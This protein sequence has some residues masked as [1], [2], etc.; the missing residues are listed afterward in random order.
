[1]SAE[2]RWFNKYVQLDSLPHWLCPACSKGV[3]R[4]AENGFS[5][6]LTALSKRERD[7]EAWQRDWDRWS[8]SLKLACTLC[9]EV[10]ICVGTAS[11]DLDV[12]ERGEMEYVQYLEPRYFHPSLSLVSLPND[13]P[14]ECRLAIEEACRLLWASPAASANAL[15]RAV[16]IFLDTQGVVKIRP[17]PNGKERR[18]VLDA[19]LE[20]FAQ[21]QASPWISKLLMPIRIIGNAGSHRWDEK[22]RQ[23]LVTC[24]TLIEFVLSEFYN[25]R[26]AKLA[27]L[28]AE[29][30]GI[31]QRKGLPKP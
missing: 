9:A 22:M 12:D 11:V 10:V 4:P 25:D 24:F 30:D 20:I 21:E 14:Q 7:L 28:Q 15:R 19:R 2:N 23:S 31:V 29:A 18:L 1:M 13:V 27:N 5:S 3:L 6:Y 17:G 16:E 8:F 26:E